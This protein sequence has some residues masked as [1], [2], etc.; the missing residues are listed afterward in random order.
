MIHNL[1]I[2]R[3]LHT[4]RFRYLLNKTP[5][6]VFPLIDPTTSKRSAA[7]IDGSAP[8]MRVSHQQTWTYR[9]TSTL[10]AANDH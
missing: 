7:A 5:Y 9:A 10:H 1:I 6:T 4:A 3:Q 2:P 8:L